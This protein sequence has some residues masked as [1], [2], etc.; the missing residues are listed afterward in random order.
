VDALAL[1]AQGPCPAAPLSAGDALLF[2]LAGAV[3]T[4]VGGVVGYL[5]LR[6]GQR[7]T[8][9]KIDDTLRTVVDEVAIADQRFL[10]A[11]RRLNED[12]D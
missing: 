12:E 6:T 3:P 1:F 7:E 8:H 4:L 2:A 5:K 11:R 9:A 10:E